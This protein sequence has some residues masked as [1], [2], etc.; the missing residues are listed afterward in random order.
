V[1]WGGVGGRRN[2]AAGPRGGKGQQNEYFKRKSFF[3]ALNSL[4]II[5]TKNSQ[6]TK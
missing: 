1:G 2:G 5:E 3:F 6:L 4:S